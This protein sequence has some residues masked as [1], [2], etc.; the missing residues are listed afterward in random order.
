[1]TFQPD[2][3][4][5]ENKT[6]VK[7]GGETR[8]SIVKNAKL[9]SNK[10]RKS[11]EMERD[12]AIQ[13]G[14]MLRDLVGD[15]LNEQ[16]QTAVEAWLAAQLEAERSGWKQ[17]LNMAMKEIEKE[18]KL[19]LDVHTAIH[20]INEKIEAHRLLL[21]TVY[22][23]PSIYLSADRDMK[24]SHV[25]ALEKNVNTMLGLIEN[26]QRE[27]EK[28][29]ATDVHAPD[30]GRS[31]DG[32]T[33]DDVIEELERTKEQLVRGQNEA[34]ELEER[35]TKEIGV[36]TDTIHLHETVIDDLRA[37]NVQEVGQ[38]KDE[39]TE[40][41]AQ[42]EATKAS[43]PKNERH[44]KGIGVC[45][46]IQ[47]RECCI[48]TD[49]DLEDLNDKQVPSTKS[50]RLDE[51]GPPDHQLKPLIEVT[52]SNSGHYSTNNNV[53][54]DRT[55][56][57]S[58][59]ESGNYPRKGIVDF[60][61]MKVSDRVNNL[62]HQVVTFA[63]KLEDARWKMDEYQRQMSLIRTNPRC[64]RAPCDVNET[65]PGPKL[66]RKWKSSDGYLCGIR[67]DIVD[68]PRSNWSNCEPTSKD[69]KR[70]K[71]ERNIY[72]TTNTCFRCHK[73]YRLKENHRMACRYHPKGKQNIERYDNT[74]K[75]VK[76]VQVWEC[77]MQ[78]ND[79]AGCSV[80]E[81]I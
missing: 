13:A 75:L 73:V 70:T 1:M 66:N 8:S 51:L 47:M 26:A 15:S 42:Q 27:K 65:A 52:I 2:E 25:V 7:D 41:R 76:I 18:R 30:T 14:T 36:L 44:D 49:R 5:L 81:H 69:C 40:L 28:Q 33:I 45:M 54:A 55:G 74:G 39:L 9:R 68:S 43:E 16:Q 60:D 80:G 57:H 72:G 20:R 34:R 31:R 19:A 23:E 12:L 46:R 24:V 79:A 59:L 53:T 3:A 61:N 6:I 62:R 50:I 77:C 4:V 32:P 71:R 38:L 29:S 37:N 17:K 35:L 48:Q 21:T 56:R 11:M 63:Q 22:R 58:L 10:P 64:R 78:Q 67:K